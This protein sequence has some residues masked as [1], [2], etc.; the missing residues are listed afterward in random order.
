MLFV[1]HEQQRTCGP[2]RQTQRYHATALCKDYSADPEANP[3][4]RKLF[5][6][7]NPPPEDLN[8]EGALKR[9]GVIADLCSQHA[10]PVHHSKSLARDSPKRFGMGRGDI[11]PMH[12]FPCLNLG[13]MLLAACWILLF[14]ALHES[15]PIAVFLNQ[16]TIHLEPKSQVNCCSRSGGLPVRRGDRP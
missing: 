4:R 7:W 13:I 10:F 5:V 9:Q 14:V 12:I 6:F 16:L 8:N 15:L 1:L 2:R 3:H 11:D